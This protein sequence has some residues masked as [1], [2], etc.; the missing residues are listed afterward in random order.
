[1]LFCFCTVPTPVINIDAPN[2]KLVG[3]LLTL[4]C[5][6]TTV[7]GI[8]SRLD[9]VWSS[10]DIELKRTEGVIVNSITDE[11]MLFIDNYT[12]AQLS[13]ADEGRVLQ[14]EIEI[15]ANLTVTTTEFIKLN[16]T[17]ECKHMCNNIKHYSYIHSSL[18]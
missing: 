5:I 4:Q 2:I 1:M 18:Y 13:T 9:I 3:Q 12:I 16:V 10:N 11:S 14:C 17:G 15:D 7:R 6:V 8:T